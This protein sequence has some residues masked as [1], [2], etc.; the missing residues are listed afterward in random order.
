D[1]DL[2]NDLII[3]NETKTQIKRIYFND[4][5]KDSTFNHKKVKLNNNEEYNKNGYRYMQKNYTTI[6]DENLNSEQDKLK[7]S[8]GA[9]APDKIAEWIPYNDLQNI[10]YYTKGGFSEIYKAVW[11]N[12]YYYEWDSEKKNDW[13]FGGRVN[14]SQVR[15]TGEATLP[16]RWISSCFIL[17]MTKDAVIWC[18]SSGIA[19]HETRLKIK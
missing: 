5:E 7:F 6:N 11:K 15:E 9:V 8:D 17:F 16:L 14:V 1:F 12:G 19:Q 3:E 4:D 13:T 2:Q 18:S 10:Q